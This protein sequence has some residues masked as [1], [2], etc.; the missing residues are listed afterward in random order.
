LTLI[1]ALAVVAPTVLGAQ[2]ADA[3]PGNPGTPSN[4]ATLYTE[5]FENG[6]GTNQVLLSNYTGAAPTNEAY[7]ADQPWLVG[8]NGEI[9]EFNTPYTDLGNCRGTADTSHTR[10]LAYA[11]GVH[12]G[13]SDPATN[14][15]VTAYTDGNPGANAVEFATKQPISLPDANGRFV[16]F[17]V[18]GAAQN[19]PVSAPSY[20]FALIS[21]STTTPVGGAINP[22]ASGTAVN[23]PA[24]G[25]E[26]AGPVNAG[27]YTS[28]GSVLLSGSS[29]GIRMTNGNGSGQGN[30][31]AF[32][33]IQIL[34]ATPQLDKAFSPTTIEAGDSSTLT[35]TVT[36]TSELAAKNGW[37][38]TDSLP[39]GL[40]VASP[41]G[42]DGSCPG[43]TVTAAAGGTSIKVSGNLGAGMAS[44]TVSVHVTGTAAGSY[45][46]GPDNVTTTGLNPP[47]GSTLTV[48][49]PPAWTCDAFG[50]L[51]Q[52]PNATT[53][54]IYR[55]DLV[56]GA[57]TQ[58]DTTADSVNAVG[59]NTLDNY[60][61][62]W[63]GETAT[64]VQI[65]ADGH[66][67]SLGVPSGIPAGTGYNVG[68]FDSSGHLWLTTSAASTPW[69]EVDLAPG[70]STYGQ[71]I[72][73]GTINAPA[74]AS[75][76][77][78][79][80]TF[81]NGVLYGGVPATGGTGPARLI[82]FDTTSH[83]VSNLGPLPGTT[84]ATAGFGADYADAAGNVY[85][86][87]NNSGNI[88][89]VKPTTRATILLSHGPPSG[90]NDG[91]RC[92]SAPI[93]TITVV[94][95]VQGRI[96][97]DDQFTVGLNGPG[98]ATLT[99]AT[100]SGTDTSATTDD[101][102][103]QANATYTVTDAMA[104]GSPD[105]L[106][107]Y[108]PTVACVDTATGAPVTTGG[109]SPQWTVQSTDADPIT[110]TV[111]N[112]PA[113]PSY[114]VTKTASAAVAHPGDTVTY[115]VTVTNTGPVPY[116]AANPASFSDDLTKVLDDA[117]YDNDVTGGAT[118]S[119]PTLSW[120]GPLAVGATAT[121]TYSVTVNQPDAG[122]HD[123]AN[124]A[125]PTAPGGGCADGS[126]PPCAPTDVA[127]QSYSVTKA[128][129]KTAAAAG[130]TITYTVTVTNTGKGAYTAA[131]PASFSDDLSQVL[132]DATYNN[133]ATN[134]ATYSAPTLSWSGPLAVGATVAVTYS[135]TVD[136]PDAGD[137]DLANAASPTGPG[138][139]CTDGSAPPC[140]PTDV[141]VQ[142]Y[143]VAK[144]A[145]STNAAPG[146]TITYTVTVTN[147]GH[148]DYTTAA[149]ASFS[150]DLSKVLDD[151]TYNNDATNGA[152]VTGHTLTWSG[153][154]A[155]GATA[156]VTYS[157]TVND[158]DTGDRKLANAA[159]PT[160][161]GGTCADGSAAPCPDTVVP[162]RSYTVVKKASSATVRPG[163]K[164]TYT[165]TVTNTGTGAYT[166][167][168]PASFSDDLSKVLDDAT[169]DK[170]ATGGAT[171]S[172]HTLSWSGALAVGQTVTV[173]YSVTVKDPDRGDGKL[174]NVV[175]TPPGNGG[176]N[177]GSCPAGTSNPDCSTDTGV[178][179]PAPPVVSGGGSG[180]LPNT[181]S[182]TEL[183]LVVAGLLLGVGGLLAL[184]RRRRE[185]RD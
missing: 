148:A 102:P 30:D 163:D 176:A 71:V 66:L 41:N 45:T 39:S 150:D 90:G 166:A 147:T 117:A 50:Y 99:S 140:A 151:A 144:V 170:D 125:T 78:A 130:G 44:C 62:G 80:W 68:D 72:D 141:K 53:H 143:T 24:I 135:V 76:L 21:G 126:A 152:T 61:Y 132:D 110:C 27:T 123:L 149:P 179:R 14:H 73:H 70:S 138:G 134:G 133:D 59:Y 161:P 10:Q 51:F 95:Q 122:D 173:K 108:V 113:T 116:T 31:A 22:C 175:T 60:F 64:L 162:V 48:T 136:N 156:V 81:V 65:A 7:T 103:V 93:P 19:C 49:T 46:N 89:R 38:F 86:S 98:G 168:D 13:A 109:N 124:T 29:V 115:T 111:T 97:P 15:A 184:T 129:D 106:S 145:S 155:V 105:A 23:V 6:L 11:L 112:T 83:T 154:L 43:R 94:K 178:Q 107:A 12:G 55:V 158:P 35:F 54:Q 63:D 88:Y 8:C 91:A 169:Y 137:G 92:A 118:Y 2:R 40:T 177:P 67:T 153:P 79:D 114:T 17:S 183:L 146:Q 181:G 157:I 32:D 57:A 185:Q 119:A 127:V 100:T 82:G 172:G 26:P 120:S 159:D 171:V 85:L 121:V 160:V 52:T 28:N 182:D 3:A 96:Q 77:P 42:V 131:D 87:D 69:Y 101:W 165:V 84:S 34:D 174:R 164:V 180:A 47:G 167:D 37:S 33:N 58:I 56:S 5:P 25:T 9:V 20:Q 4:P 36:N 1:G 18:D 75:G 139:G 128:A 104:A 142:S 16:T 74:G